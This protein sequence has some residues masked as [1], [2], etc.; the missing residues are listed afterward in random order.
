MK[1]LLL[2]INFFAVT[3]N[4]TAQLSFN[5]AVNYTLGIFPNSVTSADFNGDGK[6]IW[7]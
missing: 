6:P 3:I 2:L 5:P 4:L 7:Q 1:Q